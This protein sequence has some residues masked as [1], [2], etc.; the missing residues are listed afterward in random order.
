[1]SNLAV[2]PE[3]RAMNVS[4]SQIEGEDYCALPENIK[5]FFRFAAE[6]MLWYFPIPR[7]P[8]D[9]HTAK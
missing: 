5:E 7:I 2:G 1:M 3:A 6:V 4:L 9:E 8:D